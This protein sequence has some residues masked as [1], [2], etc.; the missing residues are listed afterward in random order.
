MENS[1]KSKNV[2]R[3]LPCRPWDI[4]RM[5][6]WLSDMA[7]E[8]LHLI[9][10]GFF[11]GVASFERG[12]K[13]QVRYRLE[14][15]LK[16]TS[17]YADDGG[18]PDDEAVELNEQLG[19]QYVAKLD[20]FYIY[21][22]E[23]TAAPELN[24][25]PE[26]QALVFKKVRGRMIDSAVSSFLY[27]VIS[28]LLWVRGGILLTMVAIST[29]LALTGAALLLW[30]LTNSI[31]RAVHFARLRKRL[32]NEGDIDHC[33]PWRQG[34]ARRTVLKLAL[35]LLAVI[36]ALMFTGVWMDNESG[37]DLIPL[38]D[39]PADPPF[40][41]MADLAPEGQYE[42]VDYGYNRR[43]NKYRLRHD[44]IAPVYIEWNETADILL[45]DGT[46]LDGSLDIEYYKTPLPWIA[47]VLAREMLRVEKYGRSLWN[48]E[49]FE[50]IDLPQID[51][52]Y[53]VGYR[54]LTHFPQLIIQKGDTVISI[55]FY[56]TSN[57]YTMPM[58]EWARIMADSLR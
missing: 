44:L 15:A 9:K 47:R 29:P 11:C 54:T 19:W 13:K 25:D 35:P 37:E 43:G 38:E 17:P 39:Y 6:S 49:D 20:G 57:T 33:K 10:D 30:G 55:Q 8:G 23:D 58:E 50:Y 18:E 53:I 14:P 42:S 48:L 2:H 51:A 21:R 41:T 32:L 24:T 45:T 46:H 34:A 4:E 5:E 16:S 52:D 22:C 56:Q 1:V 27:L 36:W 31:I 12:G 28:P 40:A 3:L 26:V 7:A